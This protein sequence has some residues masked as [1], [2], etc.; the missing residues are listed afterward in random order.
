VRWLKEQATFKQFIVLKASDHKLLG[1]S[2]QCDQD[3]D[4]YVAERTC[5]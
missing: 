4:R 1:N 2:G 5:L 3:R